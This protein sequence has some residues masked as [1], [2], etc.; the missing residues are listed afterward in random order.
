MPVP[1]GVGRWNT[2]VVDQLPGDVW[3]QA[4]LALALVALVARVLRPYGFGSILWIVGTVAYVGFSLIVVLPDGGLR[5]GVLRPLRGERVLAYAPPGGG[6][7][8]PAGWSHGLP[9]V[10]V[11]VLAA[12]IVTTV[13]NLPDA[14]A[15]PFALDRTLAQ[16]ADDA[17]LARDVVS[18]QD[19]DGSTMAGYLDR[20]VWSIARDAP[21]RFFVNDEREAMGNEGLTPRRLVC[22]AAA[23]AQR[24][25]H[26]V[27]LVVDKPLPIPDGGLLSATQGVRLYRCCPTRHRLTADAAPRWPHE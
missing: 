11:V 12:Q 8:V 13:A 17:G 1:V 19:Y 3:L 27:A 26:A 14:T 24:R 2:N 18:G 20:P 10:L 25:G 23:V 6:R 15:W 7:S 21:M 5:R 16:V 9:A 22:A 4:V